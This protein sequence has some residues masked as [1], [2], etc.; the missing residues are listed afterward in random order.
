MWSDELE[1]RWQQL[2]EEV[3]VGLRELA[4][5]AGPLLLQPRAGSDG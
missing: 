5:A 3:L 1:T 2:A 4:L